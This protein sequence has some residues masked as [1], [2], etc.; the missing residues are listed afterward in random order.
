MALRNLS[1]NINYKW[2]LFL[3][4][5]SIYT[6]FA[7]VFCAS[8]GTDTLLEWQLNAINIFKT[9]LKQKYNMLS[10]RLSREGLLK[11]LLSQNYA[12]FNMTAWN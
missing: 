9:A 10:T 11:N 5:L 4:H 7:I 3:A 12:N 8:V 2:S 1:Q 6:H